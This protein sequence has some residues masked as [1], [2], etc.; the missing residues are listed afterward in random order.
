MDEGLFIEQMC[1]V[2]TAPS[3]SIRDLA[4]LE[5]VNV[6]YHLD[7]SG[8][9]MA[10]V[11]SYVE[12]EYYLDADFLPLPLCCYLVCHSHPRVVVSRGRPEA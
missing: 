10:L 9:Y 1:T 4:A 11:I 6:D 2:N 7:R 5:C 12:A 8:G 3:C